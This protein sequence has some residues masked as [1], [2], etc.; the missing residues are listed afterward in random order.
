MISKEIKKGHVL[1]AIEHIRQ[2]GVAPGR[3][4]RKFLLRHQGN[5][6]PPK[7]VISLACQFATG[8]PLD[9]E[10]FGGGA[11]ANHFL[12]GLGFD[13]VGG[14]GTR[15]GSTRSSKV[16]LGKISAMSRERIE[17]PLASIEKGRQPNRKSRHNERCP[18]CKERMGQLLGHLYGRVQKGKSFGIPAHPEIL[19]NRYNIPLLGRIYDNLASLRHHKDFVHREH[20]S[21]CDYFIPEPGFVLEFDE[22]QHFTPARMKS[23]EQYDATVPVGFAVDRWID[24]CKR[25]DAHD[26]HP[27]YRDEQRAWYDTL[28]DFLPLLVTGLLPTVRLFAGERRWCDLSP[29]NKEDLALFR[30]WF[31]LPS[32]FEVKHRL[33]G[34]AQAFWGRVIIRGPWYGGV[35]QARSLLDAVCDEWPK[36]QRTRIL[37]TSGGFLS[38][39]WPPN[40]TRAEVDD[41]RDPD[42]SAVAAL[43]AEADIAVNALL[44]GS[45]R[46]RL[47]HCTDAIAIGVDSFKTQVSISSECIKDLHVELVYF[48]D[49]RTNKFCRTG[50]TYP[51]TGQEGGLVRITDVA[52][53]FATLDGDSVFFLGCHDLNAFSPRGNSRVKQRW[54]KEVIRGL[55]QAVKQRAPRIVV[56]LPHT[57]DSRRIWQASWNKLVETAGSVDFYASAGRYHN[58]DGP[59]GTLDSVLQATVLGGSVDSVV[60]ITCQ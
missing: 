38:F 25:I 8:K 45:L 46:S 48:L 51:T 35:R 58:S 3:Q 10:E 23:L 44:G 5:L 40:I 22:T 9:A 29:D 16:V 1:R 37:V 24:L 15:V 28:R 39:E 12:A 2:H 57:T 59:R 14:A 50:K 18:V 54:R 49:L 11:E 43:F 60:T 56:H 36:G 13:I 7:Y 19:M 34:D 53:H 52:S 6:Y 17:R 30:D 33:T 32:R 41:N 31:A 27:P 4:S 55:R 20:L 42:P 26:N 21:S 47:L